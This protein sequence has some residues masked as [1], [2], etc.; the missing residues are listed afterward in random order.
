MISCRTGNDSLFLFLIRELG[1]LEISPPKLERT[2]QLQTFRL[3]I[4][5]HIRVDFL[6]MYKLRL[7]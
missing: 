5:V 4:N 2:R 1:N 3:K 6:R 7:A